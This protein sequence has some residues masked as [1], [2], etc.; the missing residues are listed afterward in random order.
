[1]TKLKD[2]VKGGGK[3]D[4]FLAMDMPIE[5]AIDRAQCLLWYI[6][7]HR[8][9]LPDGFVMDAR[10][11]GKARTALANLPFDLK[12]IGSV[13]NAIPVLEKESTDLRDPPVT[14]GVF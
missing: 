9:V 10:I 2:Y 1:M 3:Q 14:F 4:S 6:I 11:S 5:V 8:G 13:L 7:K 12:S